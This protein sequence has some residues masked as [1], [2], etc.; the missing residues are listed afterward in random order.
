MSNKILGACSKFTASLELLIMLLAISP[1]L[2]FA[3]NEREGRPYP[4]D[5]NCCDCG[6]PWAILVATKPCNMTSQAT[7]QACFKFEE[8]VPFVSG[9]STVITNA[10]RAT[11]WL[12]EAGC[13]TAVSL[14]VNS[15]TNFSSLSKRLFE[16][17]LVLDTTGISGLE[18]CCA[19]LFWIS[20]KMP[21]KVAVPDDYKIRVS[22]LN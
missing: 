13:I 7:F 3:W 22:S 15:S 10:R 19:C 12:S 2:E 14:L 4:G 18:E 16:S 5:G 20:S 21:S 9:F 11:R 6:A 1:A 8:W 17:A